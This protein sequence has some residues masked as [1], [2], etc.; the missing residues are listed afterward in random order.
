MLTLSSSPKN[1]RYFQ[2][3]EIPAFDQDGWQRDFEDG[4]LKKGLDIPLFLPV[5]VIESITSF[6][7]L[8]DDIGVKLLRKFQGFDYQYNPILAYLSSTDETR[9]H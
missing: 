8:D 5:L 6:R 2:L 7:V 9:W 1:L 3:F 4:H